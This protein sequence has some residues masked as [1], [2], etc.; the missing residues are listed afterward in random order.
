MI[1]WVSGLVAAI[2]LA[3]CAEPLPAPPNI[4][5]IYADDLGYGDLGIFGHPTI[6]TPHLDALARSG[7]KLSAF[8]SAAP[9]CTPARAALLT[10]R[11]PIRSGMTGV[12][13]P[14]DT[15]GLPASEWTLAEALREHGYR[16]A[17]FGKWHLG[18]APGF[19]PVDHGFDTSYG[20]LY[21]ND[22]MRPWVETDVPLRLWRDN[23][24]VDEYPIDQSTLTRRLT[25]EAIAFI[26]AAG[27]TPF[28]VY[29]AHPMPHVPIYRSEAFAGVSAGGRYGDV[30]EEI[31]AS[32]GEIIA[33]L[34]AL[35]LTHNTIVLFT[36]DNG[37]NV[38]SSRFFTDDRIVATDVGSNGPYRGHKRLTLEGGMRVPGIVSWPGHLPAGAVRTGMAS[39]MDLF[40]TLL[41][42]AGVT[43]AAPNPL[44]GRDLRAFLATGAPSPH[45]VLYYFRDTRLQGVRD[46]T[47]KFRWCRDADSCTGEPELYHIQRDPYERFNVAGEHPERVD[48]LRRLMT[49]FATQTG[50]RLD[51]P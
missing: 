6:K 23:E 26:R 50:A 32:V 3:G 8:Y 46:A 18:S 7:V 43:A 5:L 22:M 37:A 15:T 41:G 45:D 17:L 36:S 42:W 38:A 28:F 11:Y 9:V 1:R 20:L 2:L 47:W 51:L 21:S 35:G 31:D 39:E 12:F 25:D 27:E 29:L 14:E 40:P 4:V 19:R 49:A 16:T 13:F 10:G 30:V 34:E 24:P 44:D 48:S 33:T